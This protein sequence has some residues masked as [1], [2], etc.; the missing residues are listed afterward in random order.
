MIPWFLAI[1]SS[2]Q[3]PNG[4]IT[5][6]VIWIWPFSARIFLL[7]LK[8]PLNFNYFIKIILYYLWMLILPLSFL[9]KA[10]T[11]WSFW[12]TAVRKIPNNSIKV[13]FQIVNFLVFYFLLNV[14]IFWYILIIFLIFYMNYLITIYFNFFIDYIGIFFLNSK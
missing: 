11:V 1:S 3:S 2:P 8:N 6:L 4:F 10:R 5:L 14:Y 13:S 12:K 7:A 9:L